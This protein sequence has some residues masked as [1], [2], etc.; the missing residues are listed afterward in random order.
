MHDYFSKPSI[1]KR[2]DFI[3]IARPE[4]GLNEE[5]IPIAKNDGIGIGQIGKLMGALNYK[6]VCE[7]T[8]PEEN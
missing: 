5:I 6:N 7:Y 2:G 4:A 1:L 8:P 3:L